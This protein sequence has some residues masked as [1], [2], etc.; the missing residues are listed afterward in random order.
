MV[1]QNKLP[2]A[3]AAEDL[4]PKELDRLRSLGYIQ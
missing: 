2:R 4:S 1:E 3:D